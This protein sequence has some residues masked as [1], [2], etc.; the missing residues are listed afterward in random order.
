MTEAVAVDPGGRPETVEAGTGPGWLP[1]PVQGM[2]ERETMWYDHALGDVAPVPAPWVLAGDTG[3][4]APPARPAA[5][6]LLTAPGV[7]SPWIAG[8]YDA[9]RV[10][11]FPYRAADSRVNLQQLAGTAIAPVRRDPQDPY[12]DHRGYPS[13]RCLFPVR[14]LVGD[15]DRWWLLDPETRTSTATGARSADERIVLTGDYRAI[16]SS[17]GW[18]RGAIVA[19]EQGI[20][21]RH[22]ASLADFAGVQ[23]WLEPAQPGWERRAELLEVA[24]HQLYSPPLTLSLGPRFATSALGPVRSAGPVR[25]VRPD[26]ARADSSDSLGDLVRS[27]R[28]HVL[29]GGSAPLGRSVPAEDLSPD[30]A[31][32]GPDGATSWSEVIWRRSAGRMPHRRY[33]FRLAERPLP[34]GTIERL[35]RW[36]VRGPGGPLGDVHGLF[37][38]RLVTS[39]GADPTGMPNGVHQLDHRLHI[40]PVSEAPKDPLTRLAAAYG[41]PDSPQAANGLAQASLVWCV[42]ARPR[43]VVERFGPWGWTGLHQAAGW[44]T[45]GLCLAAAQLGLVARPVRAFDERRLEEALAL[46]SDQ[47]VAMTVVV[48]H[49]QPHGGHQIDLRM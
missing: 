40:R 21:L 20:L 29:V 38:H 10:T 15:G 39:S 33:G 1:A 46:E 26:S 4:L 28:S 32:D 37:E 25:G 43:A 14:C 44:V 34:A 22:L 2:I 45:Q 12:N 48:G 30:A 17:Y 36:A 9:L 31:V 7:T 11:V 23:L 27:Y 8:L 16:P 47:M 41:Y 42:T 24:D 5:A 6:Q 49:H 13:A 18:F 19:A 3:S 35:G